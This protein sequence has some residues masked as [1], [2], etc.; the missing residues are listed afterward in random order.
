MRRLVIVGAVVALAVGAVAAVV[1]ASPDIKQPTKLVFFDR[2]VKQKDIDL[3]RRGFSMGE[4]FI[5]HD[6]LKKAG[7]KQGV[8]DGHCQVTDLSRKAQTATNVCTV[9]ARLSNGQI[10]TT[11]RIVFAS[12]NKP[13][14]LGV[15]GG[16]GTF[17]NARGF[18]EVENLNQSGTLSKVTIHL[19][20]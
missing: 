4:M 10:E 12:G 13:F 6:V 8:L 3:G 2:T 15:T 1:V 16:T 9:A 11:G 14:R 20:P 5:F 18:V 17:R 7:K 19:I